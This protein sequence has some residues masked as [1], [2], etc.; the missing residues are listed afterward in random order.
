VIAR[1]IQLQVSQ[2]GD[3]GMA[4]TL[5]LVLLVATLILLGASQ[6]LVRSPARRSAG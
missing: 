2:L 3:W 5:S 1:M 6:L 4:A